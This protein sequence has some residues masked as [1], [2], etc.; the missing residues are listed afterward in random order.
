MRDTGEHEPIDRQTEP[1]RSVYPDDQQGTTSRSFAQLLFVI[2]M[3]RVVTHL[4]DNVVIKL[5]ET[6]AKD[7]SRIFAYGVMQKAFDGYIVILCYGGFPAEF[8]AWLL[9]HSEIDEYVIIDL[10]GEGGAQQ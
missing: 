2:C 1:M 6:T 4:L 8:V 10:L 5:N 9:E 3:K 7:R